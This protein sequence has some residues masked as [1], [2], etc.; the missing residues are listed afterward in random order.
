MALSSSP[1][2]E[3][4][5]DRHSVARRW[6]VPS[7]FA[8]AFSLTLVLAVRVW[9]QSTDQPPN[10]EHKRDGSAPSAKP[11]QQSSWKHTPNDE[12][13]YVPLSLK[14]KAYLFGW[15]SI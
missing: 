11:T 9:G 1:S 15:R 5:L 10:V 12:Q 3:R 8:W 7:R 2:P 14:H 6:C 4:P 13:P